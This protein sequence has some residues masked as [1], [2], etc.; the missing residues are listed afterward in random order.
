MIG[1]ALL[2]VGW[3]GFN[4]VS[5]LGANNSAGMTMLVTHISAAVASLTW[6]VV[7]VEKIKTGK[8]SL[9]G[10]V[11]GMVAGLASIT[12]ASAAVGPMGAIIIGFLAGIICYFACDLLKS[13]LKID[14]SL[15]VFAVH[16]VG[17]FM[18]TLL[19]AF[20]GTEMFGGQRITTE[21][22]ISQSK[23]QAL[24][25]GVTLVWSVVATIIFVFI[26]KAT[27][28]LR[29]INEDEEIGLDLAEQGEQ[30]YTLWTQRKSLICTSEATCKKAKPR[31]D[32]SGR[33]FY[34]Q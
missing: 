19:A 17:G 15:D 2:W 23:T 24:G 29:V 4:A 10:I 8:P 31:P 30:S 14:D 5:R 20:L 12:P 16:G 13:G 27:V 3:F 21:T 11:T 7:V 34:N 33:G 22:A 1:A 9:V 6:M 32:R 26:C 25:V 18:G 28:G